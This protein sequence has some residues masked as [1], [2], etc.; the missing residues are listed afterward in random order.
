MV[1][2]ALR[3]MFCGFANS[4]EIRAFSANTPAPCQSLLARECKQDLLAVLPKMRRSGRTDLSD[5]TV[6]VNALT[7]VLEPL[8]SVA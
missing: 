6:S 1:R 5:L 2:M 7:P 8:Y 4:C 3:Q